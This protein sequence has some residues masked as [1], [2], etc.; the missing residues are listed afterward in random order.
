MKTRSLSFHTHSLPIHTYTTFI[1]LLSTLHNQ[2]IWQLTPFSHYLSHITSTT[3]YT[4][5]S[6]IHKHLSKHSLTETNLFIT[7]SLSISYALLFLMI[8][9]FLYPFLLP[10]NIN[11]PLTLIQPIS[12]IFP[13]FNINP[14]PMQYPRVHK[15]EHRLYPHSISSMLSLIVS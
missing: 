2:S 13:H 7:H 10:L 9:T 12:I 8:S 1:T 14:M 5:F 11:I 3:Q 4:H 15:H 6:H